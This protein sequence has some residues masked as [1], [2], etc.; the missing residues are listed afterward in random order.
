MRMICEDIFIFAPFVQSLEVRNLVT[1]WLCGCLQ[2]SVYRLLHSSGV[3][4]FQRG[5][6]GV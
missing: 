3:S 4:T 5:P 2:V 6:Q 1:L